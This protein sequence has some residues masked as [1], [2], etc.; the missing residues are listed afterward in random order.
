M[1]TQVLVRARRMAATGIARILREE[2]G[3]SLSEIAA[4]VGVTKGTIWRWEHGERRPRGEAARRY[5][6]VLDGLEAQRRDR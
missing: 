1:D 3:L 6:E 5:V 2:A 4:D